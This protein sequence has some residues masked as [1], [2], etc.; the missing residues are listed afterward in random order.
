MT[1]KMKAFVRTNA[2]NMEVE[3]VEVSIPSVDSHEVLIEVQAFGVG[4]HDRYF[5]P[6]D[7]AFPYIIG[8]EG[9]GTI[10]EVGSGVT[11][12]KVGD[13]VIFTS[14]IQKKGGCWAQ[15][16]AVPYPSLFPLSANM[17]FTAG[18]AIPVAG[19]TA[20]ESIRALALSKGDTLFLAG[21]SGAIG[22]LVI[23]LAA[24]R[25]IRVVGSASSKNHEYMLS[26]G[27]EK[28]VDY[29]ES[30]WR[31]HVKEWMPQGVDAALA[32]QP[33]TAIDSLDV[34]K[35]GGKVITVSGDQVEKAVRNI[36]VKQFDH[37]EE[38]QQAVFGLTTDIA[39]GQIRL[40]NENI[41]PFEEAL[42]ALKK[43]EARHA[44]GKLVVSLADFKG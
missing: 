44:R 19:K 10:I 26:L 8:S 7:A 39:N 21:A 3:F 30:N 1:G 13:R 33:G 14:P 5:I 9:A 42:E 43:T 32:I 35:D 11:G 4:I 29:K 15:Y 31:D 36:T 41:Y 23:Q 25:G 24:Q 34:V 18:A 27:A 28:A 20:L 12:Y 37:H 17:E 2:Q 16:V 40:V 6:G 22:T 38:T